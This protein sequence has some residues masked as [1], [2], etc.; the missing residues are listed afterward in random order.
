M[1]SMVW[2]GIIISFLTFLI[3]F[4]NAIK[5]TRWK[6]S[7]KFFFNFKKTIFISLLSYLRLLFLFN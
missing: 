6:I 5:L 3:A 4:I 7:V 1:I 2:L